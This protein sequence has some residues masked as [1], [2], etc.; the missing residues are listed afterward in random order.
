MTSYFF[1][2]ILV[3]RVK[4][5][6]KFWEALDSYHLPR[7]GLH[8]ALSLVC[9]AQTPKRPCIYHTE[10]RRSKLYPSYSKQCSMFR[11]S[12]LRKEEGKKISVFLQIE[13]EILW[14]FVYVFSL[15]AV[16]SLIFIRLSKSP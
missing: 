16:G 12:G 5:P 13:C 14:V 1:I 6:V 2:K 7:A 3:P 15:V 11:V 10:G 9:P 4:I 8:P